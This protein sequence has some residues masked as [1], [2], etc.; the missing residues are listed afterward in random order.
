M[1]PPGNIAAG[2]HQIGLIAIQRLQ[3]PRQHTRRM[4]QVRVHHPEHAAARR[5]ESVD[6]R[7]P[8]PQLARP[9]HHPHRQPRA[10][11][12]R[13]TRPCPS[14][15]LSSTMTISPAMP[16]AAI[17][18]A[19]ALHEVAQPGPLV[20]GG[21]DDGEEWAKCRARDES[22][23]RTDCDCTITNESARRSL[24]LASV[25]PRDR[26]R[27]GLSAA[28]GAAGSPLSFMRVLFW[29]LF[30]A[31]V[32]VRVPSLAQPAGG[33]QALYAY[34][35]QR[36]LAG[37]VPYRDAW[38]QKPPAVHLAYAALI[39]LWPHESICGSRRR[40]DRRRC[41]GAI[42]RRARPLP[43]FSLPIPGRR[44]LIHRRIFRTFVPAASRNPAFG[45]PW[46]RARQRA[47]CEVFVERP[48]SPRGGRLIASVASNGPAERG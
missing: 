10:P 39:A 40:S 19:H 15:E 36:I 31:L 28:A 46:R 44:P 21:N 43:S 34:V 13:R 48:R 2:D 1:P 6:H 17:R 30:C 24:G 7:S 14:G 12:P 35:G 37:E 18:L 45:A 23:R 38:D 41:D 25:R 32:A 27:P 3:H 22:R 26:M 8:Q 4:A 16:L 42:P 9:M 5:G 20:V 33:D 47:Q 11:V 29:L